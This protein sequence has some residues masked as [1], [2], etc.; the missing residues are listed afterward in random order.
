MPERWHKPRRR[1][2]QSSASSALLAAVG[3]LMGGA[4]SRFEGAGKGQCFGFTAESDGV[5]VQTN[6]PLRLCHFFYQDLHC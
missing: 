1:P 2:E 3:N 4:E 5:L 6:L